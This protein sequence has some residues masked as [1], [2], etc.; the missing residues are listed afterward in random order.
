LN[1][2]NVKLAFTPLNRNLSTD[3]WKA[4]IRNN[5]EAEL[6]LKN[7]FAL[8]NGLDN[9]AETNNHR[10]LEDASSMRQYT[11]LLVKSQP[12]PAPLSPVFPQTTLYA[13]IS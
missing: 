8:V 1:K 10:D 4:Y 7:P 9:Q 11:A 3:Q 5:T 2:A 6:H 12:N 13:V